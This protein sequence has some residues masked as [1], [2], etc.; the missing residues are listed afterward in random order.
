MEELKIKYKE[1]IDFTK[2]LYDIYKELKKEK[3]ILYNWS[4]EVISKNTRNVISC[5]LVNIQKQLEEN[6]HYKKQLFK[7]YDD[8]KDSYFDKRRRNDKDREE[9]GNFIQRVR[10]FVHYLNANRNKFQN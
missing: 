10:A 1:N 2:N 4:E 6:E 3:E 5:R 9:Y 8:C 7:L